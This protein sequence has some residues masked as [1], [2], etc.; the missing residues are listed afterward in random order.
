RTVVG[1]VAVVVVV[2]VAFAS[3]IHVVQHDAKDLGADAR[4]LLTGALR[5]RSRAL[6]ALHYEYHSI[7]HARKD[8]GI[9]HVDQ[10]RRIDEHVI[11]GLAHLSNQSLHLQAADQ[12]R[13]VWRYRSASKQREIWNRKLLYQ[14]V[15][16]D[17]ARQVSRQSQ[18]VIQPEELVRRRSSKIA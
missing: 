18:R 5:D 11:V 2:V 8:H 9:G 1:V 6:A 16:F 12:L 13:R 14:P 17:V 4:K 10:R 7:D 3:K 15:D